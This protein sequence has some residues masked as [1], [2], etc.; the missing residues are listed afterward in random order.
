MEIKSNFAQT[1]QPLPLGKAK[2]HLRYTK[3]V[4]TWSQ[5]N[6]NPVTSSVQKMVKHTFKILQQILLDF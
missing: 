1:D 4:L 6:L 3:T 2:V 5:L